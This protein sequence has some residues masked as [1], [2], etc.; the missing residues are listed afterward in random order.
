MI[1]V[2]FVLVL[3]VSFVVYGEVWFVVIEDCVVS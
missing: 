2:C 3:G 1:G